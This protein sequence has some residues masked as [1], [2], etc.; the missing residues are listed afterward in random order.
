MGIVQ[1]KEIEEMLDCNAKMCD[2][3]GS[4]FSMTLLYTSGI[5]VEGNMNAKFGSRYRGRNRIES[6]SIFYTIYFLFT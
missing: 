2:D 3:L 5:R 1:G 6:W 4:Q